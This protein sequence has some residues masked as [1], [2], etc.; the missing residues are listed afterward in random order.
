VGNKQSRATL[1][2]RKHFYRLVLG[3]LLLLIG[4]YLYHVIAG[5]HLVFHPAGVD[6]YGEKLYEAR[7]QRSDRVFIL[8][9]RINT[10]SNWNTISY[11]LS[12]IDNHK[13]R[14]LGNFTTCGRFKLESQQIT[15]F[16]T[17]SMCGIIAGPI[18]NLISIS[19]ESIVF[20]N[21]LKSP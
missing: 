12:T 11:K 17:D 1:I 16:K 15:F 13:I 18:T 2:N 21:T 6:D 14:E 3:L 7:F 19:S 5:E 20:I 8:T 4:G 9:R 10:L